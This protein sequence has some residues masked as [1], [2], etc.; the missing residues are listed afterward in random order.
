[1]NNITIPI[2]GKFTR[3]SLELDSRLT[4]DDW[5]SVGLNL[6]QLK[7]WSNFA[8]G[9]WLEY[10]EIHYGEQ[11]SQAASDTGISEDKLMLFKHVA[12]RVDQ[13][14]R[15]KSLSWSH[16]LEVAKLR[17]DEQELWLGLAEKSRWSVRDLREQLII[18]GLRESKVAKVEHQPWV[19]GGH[20]GS[21][22]EMVEDWRVTPIQNSEEELPPMTN[23]CEACSS[24]GAE[25]VYLC[26]RCFNEL[27]NKRE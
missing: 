1:M 16:H 18:A 21:S 14:R 10:G 7:D 9:D 25:A 2:P 5:R 17:P 6:A 26:A 13:L 24:T 19:R 20:L 8:I 22:M 15:N 3:T 12:H 11:Y 23:Q 27:L 4:Y